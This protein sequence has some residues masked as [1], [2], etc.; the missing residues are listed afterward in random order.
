MLSTSLGLRHIY[1][2]IFAN[3]VLRHCS[4]FCSKRWFI[5]KLIFLVYNRYAVLPL[6][7]FICI[8]HFTQLPEVKLQDFVYLN[9]TIQFMQ[10]DFSPGRIGG[11]GRF[12]EISIKNMKNEKKNTQVR[13]KLRYGENLR[14][15]KINLSRKGPHLILSQ[16]LACEAIKE[17]FLYTSLW[18]FRGPLVICSH[19]FRASFTYLV[20]PAWLDHRFLP[21]TTPLLGPYKF[22]I[23][24][25]RYK[26]VVKNGY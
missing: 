15:G 13:F 25:R 3:R 1:I 19:F 14:E 6:V 12:S 11:G 16:C 21:G 10:W 22:V 4:I 24:I 26:Q 9:W 7:Y 23:W 18:Y 2:G 20:I 5:R 17:V 8:F